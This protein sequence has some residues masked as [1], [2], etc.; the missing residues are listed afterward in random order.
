M[1]LFR[2]HDAVSRSAGRR[3]AR[4]AAGVG[5]V[6]AAAAVASLALAAPASAHTPNISVA[7]VDGG[8]VITVNLTN[9]NGSKSNVVQVTD[10]TTA[11]LDRAFGDHDSYTTR[12]AGD[13]EH[14]FKVVVK[15]WDDLDGSKGWSFTKTKTLAACVA[16][17]APPTTTTT[18]TTT[19]TATT[20]TTHKTSAAPT[21]TTSSQ[22]V[23][24][25]PTTSSSAA[26]V[27]ATTSTKPTALPK[28]GSDVTPALLLGIG[29]FG[30]GAV[31]LFALQLSRRRIQRSGN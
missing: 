27:V 4:I 21:T 3:T 6:V 17:T 25:V 24:V 20:T 16:F 29:L 14:T 1:R 22:P 11:L 23:V 15:A 13:V 31:A 19:A 9:Y 12:L 8:A 30:V 7:C 26:G 10:G 5:S 28:T 18:T 2:Q